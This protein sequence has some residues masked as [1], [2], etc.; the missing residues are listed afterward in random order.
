[1]KSLDFFNFQSTGSLPWAHQ[2]DRLVQMLQQDRQAA[3]GADFRDSH[4]NFRSAGIA[5]PAR[6]AIP[7][8]Q[9]SDGFFHRRLVPTGKCGFAG[10][11]D[12]ANTNADVCRRAHVHDLVDIGGDF[13]GRQILTGVA[14]VL[15]DRH[16]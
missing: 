7:S 4:S 6:P 5:G 16:A 1:M 3:N 2:P 9:K 12:S 8:A 11:R 10:H 15:H 14:L 13:L